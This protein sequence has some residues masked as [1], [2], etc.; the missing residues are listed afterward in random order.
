MSAHWRS[1]PEGG[2]NGVNNINNNI[3]NLNNQNTHLP[4]FSEIK[5]AEQ[6]ENLLS[7]FVKSDNNTFIN[8]GDSLLK[9]Y[10]TNTPDVVES[11]KQNLPTT[12]WDSKGNAQKADE[13]G[14]SITDISIWDKIYNKGMA[15]IYNVDSLLNKPSEDM[16]REKTKM[17]LNILTT[18]MSIGK[19]ATM[20]IASKLTPFL[21][22]KIAQYV[23]EGIGNGIVSGTIE[24]AFDGFENQDKNS[25]ITTSEGALSGTIRGALDGYVDSQISRIKPK[26]KNYLDFLLEWLKYFKK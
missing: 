6:Q 15:N 9:G 20:Q 1:K 25:L 16:D 18:P 11:E 22:E 21:G 14:N 2:A 8:N 24:G 7:G 4:D 10:I 5:P 13:N 26:D 17:I 12:Y 19:F 23:A 3:F